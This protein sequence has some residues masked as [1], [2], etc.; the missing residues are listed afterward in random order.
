VR[1]RRAAW[2]LVVALLAPIGACGGGDER[3]D[4]AGEKAVDGTFVGKLSGSDVFVA[5]VASPAVRG[6]ARRKVTV[7]VADGGRVNESLSGE[8]ERNTFVAASEDAEAKGTLEGNS[9]TGDVKLPDGKTVRYRATRASA[10]AGLY[11]LTVSR[12]GQ[13]SGASATGV[14]LTSKST[15]RAPGSGR[16]KFADGKR[17][18]FEVVADSTGKPVRLGPGRA[19]LIVLPDGEL[20]GAGEGRPTGGGDEL[21]FFIRSSAG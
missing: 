14:G 1:T 8:A 5:V 2:F 15:L 21:G 3:D 12:K 10:A 4:N 7:Y 20:S 11:D 6:Q 18:R 9:V 17:R 16:I 19:R 13:L